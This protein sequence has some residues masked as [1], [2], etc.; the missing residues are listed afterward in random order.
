MKNSSNVTGPTKSGLLFRAIIGIFLLDRWIFEP[1]KTIARRPG[2]LIV[3]RF[4]QI[5][6]TKGKKTMNKK[7]IGNFTGMMILGVAAI[8][9]LAVALFHRF[10]PA[11]AAKLETAADDT[12][13]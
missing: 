9:I 2:P 13:G 11:A 10:A 3:F 1:I 12:E 4:H 5:R 8:A 6:P 7:L